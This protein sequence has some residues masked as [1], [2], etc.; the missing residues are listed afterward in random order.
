MKL[1]YYLR[2]AG[3]GM[4]A[5][6]LLLMIGYHVT[7][8]QAG[9]KETESVTEREPSIAEALENRPEDT[10]SEAAPLP[11]SEKEVPET[12]S[13]TEERTV[14]TEHTHSETPETE[15]AK[16]PETE[17]PETE[18]SASPQPKEVSVYPG[19]GPSMIAERLAA[20]G[21]VESAEDF[22]EYLR[23]VG[24]T[25]YLEIGTFLLTPGDDFETIA[26]ILTTPE[27]NR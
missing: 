16:I 8:S 9:E 25:D 27:E 17:M 5:A 18:I 24:K 10:E 13:E 20:E 15:E 2:G 21:I 1:K 12:E 6:T 19:E 14:I 3:I 26:K 4:I 22:V 7:S 23:S 11:E